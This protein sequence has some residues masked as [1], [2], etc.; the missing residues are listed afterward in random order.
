[1]TTDLKEARRLAIFEAAYQVLAEKGYKGTSML[2]VAKAAG[3]S[4]ETLYNWFGNKQGLLAAM[5]EENA[6]TASDVLGQVFMQE[7]SAATPNTMQRLE[8][9]GT[10]L[11]D[12]LTSERSVA[13]NRAAAADV[14]AGGT[15]GALLSQH[16]RQKVMPLLA[17]TFEH[18]QKEGIIADHDT[19]EIAE[20]YV[21]LLL[22]DI[23]IRRVIGALQAPNAENTLRHSQR[24]IELILDLFGRK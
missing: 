15:L 19:E 3:A 24:V 7:E 18:A 17:Q 10:V 2:A 8:H 6:R 21:T 4:N 13:L 20:I 11:L 14:S 1:M 5:I 9:F 12:L 16:G 23:Q 22:G